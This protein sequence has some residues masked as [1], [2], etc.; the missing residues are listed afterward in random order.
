[1]LLNL[2][3][4]YVRIEPIVSWKHHQST[5]HVTHLTDL[6]QQL[7]PAHHAQ[8]TYLSSFISSVTAFVFLFSPEAGNT[9][10]SLVD[11]MGW[12]STKHTIQKTLAA[13]HTVESQSCTLMRAWLTEL[14]LS[15]QHPQRASCHM[16]PAWEKVLSQNS[17]YSFYWMSRKAPLGS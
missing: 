15:A 16:S 12:E 8:D 10:G 5:M 2:Q 6:T 14:Q 13:Q 4:G 1:M 17:K 11:M 3:R 9:H 7:C